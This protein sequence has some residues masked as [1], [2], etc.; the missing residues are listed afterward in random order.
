MFHSRLCLLNEGAAPRELSPVLAP[1]DNGDATEPTQQSLGTNGSWP[2]AAE[3][4]P[5]FLAILEP[6]FKRYAYPLSAYCLLIAC[7]GVLVTI[8]ILNEMRLDYSPI[9]AGFAYKTTEQLWHSRALLRCIVCSHDDAVLVHLSCSFRLGVA[10]IGR[11][12]ARASCTRLV[13]RHARAVRTAVVRLGDECTRLSFERSGTVL[14]VDPPASVCT[15]VAN[16]CYLRAGCCRTV[17]MDRSKKFTL[18]YSYGPRADLLPMPNANDFL[19]ST[20]IIYCVNGPS[21]CR[22]PTD[23]SAALKKFLTTGRLEHEQYK[24]IQ[25]V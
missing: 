15:S 2:E 7:S 11:N 3:T 5:R 22:W 14:C 10:A 21:V 4:W 17:R 13:R 19:L 9:H 8:L 18:L 20:P 12:C 23:H 24:A 25:A 1:N 16:C 6:R